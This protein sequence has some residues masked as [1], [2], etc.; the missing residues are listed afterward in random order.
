MK[1][2][3]INGPNLNLLG[4]RQREIYG[5]ENFGSYF[6]KLKQ[7]FKTIELDCYQSNSEGDII[8]KL[9]EVGFEFNGIII[10]AGAYS[11]TSIAIADAIA[12]IT[13]PVVE[14]HISN[15]YNRERFR[16]HSYLT[17]NCKGLISGFGLKGYDMA[18]QSFL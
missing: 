5:T 15:I 18:V 7:V 10:N 9:H 4:I 17:K 14:V 8:D 2:I 16:R 12:A 6:N 3:I 1:L 13:A 11:H